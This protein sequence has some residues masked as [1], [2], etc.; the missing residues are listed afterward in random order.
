MKEYVF[1]VETDGLLDDCTKEF[2]IVIY[3]INEEKFHCFHGEELLDGL[4]FLKNSDRLIGHNIVSFDI[5]VLKKIFK[6][7]PSANTEIVDTLVMSKLIYPDRA[8]R[9][10]KNNTIDKDMYGR[11]SLKSWG[12]RLGL[13]KGDFSD[14]TEFSMEM[15]TYCERDVELNVLL[16]KKL[17]EANFSEDSIR[18]E[19]DIHK[20]CL[21]QTENGFPFDIRKASKLYSTLAEKRS[22]LQ[23]EL[24]EA[25]G[26]WIESETFIPKVNNKTRGYVKGVPFI[27]EKTIEFNPNSRKHIAKRLHDIHG[28]VPTEFTPTEEPKIDESVLAKLSYPEA[29][30]MAEAFRVNKLIAQLSEGKHA[31]LYHEKDGKI[32]GSVNT[33]GSV[34]SRCSHSHP[35]I[36]Q[37]PSVK[38]FYGRE[39][40][41]LFYAPKGFS[42]LGCDVS[43]LEIRVVSHYLASYDNGNYAKTVVEGDIHESN[44]KATGLPT[45][46][47]AKTFIYGLLYGAGDTK[48][49]EIVGKDAR[50]GKKLKNLF[51]KK[52]PAFKKLRQ[53]VFTASEKGFLFGLDGR[54]VPIRS[55]HSSLNAL[56]QS[57]G[58]IICKKWVVEF[59][60]LMKKSG[61]IDGLDYKQVAFVHDEIQVLVKKGIEEKVGDIAV[62][63]ISIAGKQLY[64]K[65]PLTG[66]YNFGA[67]WAETH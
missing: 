65:V 57:A 51:F 3:D 14:F 61:Y 47:Q 37:V 20:I 41:E 31:W 63:S 38:G 54:K 35:N 7:E 11:H 24:K 17:K 23:T 26:S 19:H 33:M 53:S 42:L 59:H 67:N 36:G 58:A 10:A 8:V 34:S 5:P 21:K 40:R 52:V 4:F 13:W 28:W 30:L 45:R 2:C 48:L 49:G 55:T 25:F 62:E 9:D 22:V 60:A 27:K 32:H 1:D 43:G 66:E 12:K 16:Y 39:C 44:R 15:L 6:W 18:L 56:C 64:L 46:D 29:Q 50:E